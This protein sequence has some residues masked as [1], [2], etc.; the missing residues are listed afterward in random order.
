MKIYVKLQLHGVSG[1]K[2]DFCNEILTEITS[3]N[4]KKSTSSNYVNAIDFISLYFTQQIVNS[5][6]CQKF[7]LINIRGIF[8]TDCTAGVHYGGSNEYTFH[9]DSRRSSSIGC[10]FDGASGA[11][12]SED[13][14]GY[15]GRSNPAF[16][17]TKYPTSTTQVW[18]GSKKWYFSRTIH[19]H[20]A[21]AYGMTRA[22][23][24]DIN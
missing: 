5:P 4:V 16:S 18:F 9:V 20:L 23:S 14:F 13:N 22:F 12:S 7:E 19:E 1:N 11:V 10:Q 8:C 6:Q 15:Y 17:C 24:Y 2:L 21:D 3:R